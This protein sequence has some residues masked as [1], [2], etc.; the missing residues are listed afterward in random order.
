VVAVVIV[1]VIVTAATIL[2]AIALILRSRRAEFSPNK[3]SG[4]IKM[5]ELS[6]VNEEAY[7]ERNFYED[8]EADHVY[9][10]PVL[11]KHDQVYEEVQAPSTKPEALQPQPSSSIG[12]FELTQC[13]AY[14]SLATT[15]H[16]IHSNT[17]K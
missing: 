10:V 3:E 8:V 1:L 6:P 13:P 9:D 14:V 5:K 16:S 11:D 4:G 12:D 15:S 2:I 17:S 7:H